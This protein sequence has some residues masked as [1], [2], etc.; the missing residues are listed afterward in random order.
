MDHLKKGRLLVLN[1][2]MTV[3]ALCSLMG[4]SV[5]TLILDAGA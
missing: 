2:K 1:F 5:G 4:N 3:S